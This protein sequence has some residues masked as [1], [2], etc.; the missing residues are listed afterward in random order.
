MTER[1]QIRQA[2]LVSH[3]SLLDRGYTMT[4]NRLQG[5][6]LAQGNPAGGTAQQATNWLY[7]QL[8]AQASVL[9]YSDVFMI[10]AIMSFAIIP[11]CFLMSGNTG[12]GSKPAAH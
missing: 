6:F 12:G 4:M 8:H 11:F 5:D 3:T 7:Q 1:S 2:H 9:A 10:T